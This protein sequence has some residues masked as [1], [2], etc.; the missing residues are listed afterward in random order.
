M[1]DKTLQ[2]EVRATTFETRTGIKAK[3]GDVIDIPADV[4]K[5]TGAI[6]HGLRSGNLKAVTAETDLKPVRSEA[7]EQKDGGVRRLDDQKPM[8]AA[9]KKRAEKE[10]A[11]KKKKED[12]QKTSEDEE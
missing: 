4:T 9:E 3:R 12:D 7:A 1:S 10:A 11:D 8:S 2:V 5:Q 6:R